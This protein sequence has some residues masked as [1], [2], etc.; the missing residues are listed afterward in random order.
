MKEK[1]KQT[2]SLI[3]GVILCVVGLILSSWYSS[4]MATVNYV[5]K[6]CQEIKTD[7]EKKFDKIDG[8][9]DQLIN[10]HLEKK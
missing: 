7:S 4:K 8:K 6:K 9:L 5:D 10:M 3:I 2:R 1:D